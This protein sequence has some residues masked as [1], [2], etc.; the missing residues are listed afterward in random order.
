MDPS[1]YEYQ[2]EFAKHF[3]S[4]GRSEGRAEG[5][6]EGRA[7]GKVEVVLKQ[8]GLRFGP[9]P[10]G[11]EERARVATAAQLDALAELVLTANSLGDALAIL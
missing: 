9:L 6:S 11:V 2:S 1:K 8:L 3:L 7:E 10:D 5:R 4:Q